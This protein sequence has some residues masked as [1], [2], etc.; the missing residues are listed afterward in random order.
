MIQRKVLERKL[1]ISTSRSKMKMKKEMRRNWV[2]S[3]E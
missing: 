2:F 3:Q 1:R